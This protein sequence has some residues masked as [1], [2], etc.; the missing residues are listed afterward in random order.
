M[1]W[2]IGVDSGGTFTDI[3][4]FEEETGRLEIWKLS[5]SP[6]DP[7]R[8]IA[9]GV[10]EGLEQVDATAGDLGFL[11]HG[12]TVATN[13][14]IEL[15][16]V[17]TGLLISDGFRDLLELGRQKRPS[18]YDMNVDKPEQLVT[19]D[20]RR[21]V[22]ER[23]ANRTSSPSPSASSMAS[24]TPRMKRWPRRSS[25]KCCR[26]CSS[27]PAMKSPRNSASSNGSRPLLSTPISARS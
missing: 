9:Q 25:R 27:P 3:C 26:T 1:V 19:R 10:V 14:L 5:S 16:G 24:S 15:R 4:L 8:A 13:A 11:G 12:T 7:S 22:P 6:D 20:L 18:L 21:Q 2:R 17:K 23:L